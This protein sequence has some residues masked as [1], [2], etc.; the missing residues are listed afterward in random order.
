M[1]EDLDQFKRLDL[2]S[3]AASHGYL[4][5]KRE[6]SEGCAVMRSSY[7]DKIII[8]QNEKGAWKYFCVHNAQ[9]RGSIF[10]FLKWRGFPTWKNQLDEVREWSGAPVP[11][12]F[13]FPAARPV[14]KDREAV[15]ASFFSAKP[16]RALSYLT[17][18]GI[19]P[20][21]LEMPA[22]ADRVRVDDRGNALFPHY[23][24]SGLCGYEIK[25]HSFTG[26]AA[27]GAKGLWYSM[28]SPAA[29]VLVFCE[30]AIDAISFYVL[31]PPK[32]GEE[33]RVFSVGGSLNGSQ[34][35]LIKA[36]MEKAPEGARVL[37]AFDHD[38]AGEDF[39]A[40][41]RALAPPSVVVSRVLPPVGMGK[42][43][44]EALKYQRGIAD[45]KAAPSV[46]AEHGK[47][48]PASAMN[49]KKS[50]LRGPLMDSREKN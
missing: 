29:S 8:T 12:A 2:R 3:F 14:V 24:K 39:A 9:D 30:S 25:N 44:N 19:G 31:N 46:G 5:D 17:A 23:D 48:P 26:F 32:E 4:L 38:E 45:P 21:V 47:T 18:R 10:D 43:W 20:D 34:P 6:S 7:G 15:T 22:F 37:L 41:V 27:G 36:A 40:R 28:A 49:H 50:P 42:D 11:A 35:N 33:M 16:A 1:K 13:Q